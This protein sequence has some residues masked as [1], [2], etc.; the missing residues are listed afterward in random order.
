MNT[1][2]QYSST[3][4]SLKKEYRRVALK[5]R[6]TRHTKEACE[7]AGYLMYYPHLLTNLTEL[8]DTYRIIKKDIRVYSQL[9]KEELKDEYLSTNSHK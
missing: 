6:E 9:L 5:L 3:L 7:D 2:T 4:K 8:S 1:I